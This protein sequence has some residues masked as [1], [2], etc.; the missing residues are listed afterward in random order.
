MTPNDGVWIYLLDL[1]VQL[2]EDEEEKKVLA[3]M[4]GHLP[5]SHAFEYRSCSLE[6]KKEGTDIFVSVWQCRLSTY[7]YGSIPCSVLQIL[8]PRSPI[9]DSRDHQIL[10]SLHK[11]YKYLVAAKSLSEPR[12]EEVTK[13]AS[14]GPLS[15]ELEEEE[16]E[17]T[18]VEE[19]LGVVTF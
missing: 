9:Q 14:G 11:P 12:I 19:D 6:F 17:W 5:S 13:V 1:V 10:T 8:T 7:E 2:T 15:I 3:F 16:S 18:I 4:R